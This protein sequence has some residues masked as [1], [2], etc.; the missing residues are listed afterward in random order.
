MSKINNL[1]NYYLE[2]D[3]LNLNN[4]INLDDLT[5]LIDN[6]KKYNIIINCINIP[7]GFQYMD[8]IKENFNKIE[9]KQI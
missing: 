8:I 3:Y 4:N 6:I 7:N 1:L 9:I 5:L 2:N